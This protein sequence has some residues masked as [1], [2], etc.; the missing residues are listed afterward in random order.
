M[1]I[2]IIGSGDVGKALAVGFLGT[3]HE[4]MIGTRDTKKLDSWKQSEA[5]G[6]QSGSFKEAGEFGE[7]LVLAVGWQHLG[8]VLDSAGDDLFK[9]KVLIDVTNPLDFSDGFPP[10]LA[11]SGNDSGGETIQRLLPK[12]K[13]VKAWNIVG[14]G[15]MYQPKFSAGTPTMWICGND[16]SSKLTVTNILNDFGWQ[17][18]IDLGEISGAR[19]LEP[20]CILW[21]ASGRRLE[22]WNIALSL[23][24][25]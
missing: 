6:A 21:V 24:K 14:N 19:I 8:A 11:I 25:K 22:N 12:A 1:K 20:M 15:S 4:V 23:L 9:D 5:H 16:D 7:L 18:V 10:K 17:D 3:G 13:V 2:G